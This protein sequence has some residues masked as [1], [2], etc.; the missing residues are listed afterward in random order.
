MKLTTVQDS[1]VEQNMV[2]ISCGILLLI[3]MLHD[4][5]RLHLW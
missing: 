2:R 3:L 5:M 4:L 1:N